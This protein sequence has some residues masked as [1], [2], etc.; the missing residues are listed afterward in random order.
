MCNEGNELNLQQHPVLRV[1]QM[2]AQSHKTI[3]LSLVCFWIWWLIWWRCSW[4]FRHGFVCQSGVT[5]CVKNGWTFI[6]GHISPGTHWGMGRLYCG[7]SNGH[8]HF[9]S[10]SSHISLTLRTPLLFIFRRVTR[11]GH[12]MKYILRS[13]DKCPGKRRSRL[14]SFYLSMRERERS[15]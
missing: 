14:Q 5:G 4:C 1:S 13:L 2:I 10:F 6:L 9:E 7:D 15:R 12:G 3:N 8:V 11:I